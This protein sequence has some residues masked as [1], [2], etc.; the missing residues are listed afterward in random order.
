MRKSWWQK[1][2]VILLVILCLTTFFAC[3]QNEPTQGLVIVEDE[4]QVDALTPQEVDELATALYGVME[5]AAS[6]ATSLAIETI[7]EQLQNIAQ[8]VAREVAALAPT[9]NEYAALMSVLGRYVAAADFSVGTLVDSLYIDLIGALHR[10]KCALLLHRLLLH[11][12]DTQA[13]RYQQRYEEI[14]FDFILADA[15]RYRT[16]SQILSSRLAPRD[17]LSLLDVYYIVGVARSMAG[18]SDTAD[19]LTADEILMLIKS[20]NCTAVVLD[21]DVWYELMT[22]ARDFVTDQYYGKIL[23]TAIDNG[24]ILLLAEGMNELIALVRHV[25]LALRAE[26]VQAI[27]RGEPGLTVL[28][29]LVE[30]DRLQSLDA[31][32]SAGWHYAAYNDLAKKQY[33]EAYQQFIRQT[34]TL[35]LDQLLEARRDAPDAAALL[36]GYLAGKSYALAYEVQ[37]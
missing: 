36:L 5:R 27:Q 35:T 7:A 21:A 3:G 14:G 4:A 20:Q 12:C 30:D 32:L 24:D 29:S 16:K 11:Y 9:E 2:I 25:Q 33:G 37:P 28:L 15:E 22:L 19:F 6:S 31:F 8:Y 1:L 34:E 13:Q 18:H 26:D 23:D 17:L 10:D